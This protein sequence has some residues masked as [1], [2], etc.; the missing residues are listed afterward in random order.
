M[1]KKVLFLIDNLGSGGAQRQ[2]I[3]LS[4]LLKSDGYDASILVY[5]DLI[6]YKRELKDFN[7]KY[8]ILESNSYVKR[9]FDI[10][11]FIKNLKPDVVISF[12]ETPNFIACICKKYLKNFKLITA[13]RSS[14]DST[15]HGLK[16]KIYNHYQKYADYICCNSE[17][18][19]EKW[20]KHYSKY[21]NKIRVIYNY[22]VIPKT[23]NEYTQFLNGKV[24]IVVAASYQE[25]KN[26]I[27]VIEALK[28]IQLEYRNKIL[29][30]WYGKKE[31]TKGNT[32]TYDYAK[33]LVDLYN[34]STSIHL[35]EETSD[36]YEKMVAS[37]FVALFSTIEGLPNTICEAMIL[38]K[39][40]I[41]S[42]V[43]DYQ[44]LVKGN[45]F[46]CDPFS[47][48]S[49][50]M[51]IEKAINI[52][53]STL[54]KMGEESKKIADNCFNKSVILDKWIQMIEG[55]E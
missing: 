40:I 36:I 45:G 49:V 42:T 23:K 37:D 1:K 38:G 39:P 48:E 9:V 12:L 19:K 20:S 10:Y 52:D 17:N 11:N 26:V 27:T 47:L 18:A 43:S 22:V 51:V 2:I 24:N 44:V 16:H 32:K 15:F 6:F 53:S 34:L 46:L 21:K 4:F 55:Y 28:N 33:E 50:K 29:I 7:L 54:G 8:Y 3:N 5:Q 13:E 35:N 25:L 31:I 30:N 41:M 14:M